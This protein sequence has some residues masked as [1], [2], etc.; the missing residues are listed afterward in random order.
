MPRCP[1]QD[2][3]Y[4]KP[5]DVFE[6]KCACC[7]RYVE[8]FKDE[9]KLRCRGCGETVTNPKIDMGC[10]K[11]C[12]YADQCLGGADTEAEPTSVMRDQLVQD[13][14]SVY[15]ED[16]N[17]VEHTLKVL[18]YADRIREAEGGDALTVT[19][20]AILH[21][22][23]IPQAQATH[24]SSAWKYQEIEGP[25]VAREILRKYQLD[26]ELTEH[27]CKIIANHHSAKDIDTLEFRIVWDADWLVN[28]PDHHGRLDAEKTRAMIEKVFKTQKGK[29]IAIELYTQ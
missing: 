13:M 1:G 12:Q 14:K 3:R 6:V 22:I 18:D 10:A 8:F 2:Q 26:T 21:D 27:V 17:R 23:G 11:W 5:G 15:G 9:P 4:W 19:A 20:A 29:E 7:G 24:G 16:V 28:F 25:A